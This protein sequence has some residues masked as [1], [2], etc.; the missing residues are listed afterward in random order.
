MKLPSG[1]RAYE[2]VETWLWQKM[3]AYA[4]GGVRN[5]EN[6]TGTDQESEYSSWNVLLNMKMMLMFPK[7]KHLYSL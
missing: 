2:Q 7:N 6:R 3:K 1:G 5:L 4:S